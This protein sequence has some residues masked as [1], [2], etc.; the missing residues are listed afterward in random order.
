MST[1][2]ELCNHLKKVI[3]LLNEEKEALI[4]NDG[5]K[6]IEIVKLKNKYIEKLSQFSGLDIIENE[7][8]INLIQEINSLQ[9]VNLL[10]TRQALSYQDVLL[11]SISQSVQNASNTYSAKGNYEDSNNINLIDKKV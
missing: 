8:A 3:K 2:V 6:I 10:L 7:K 5:G 4:Q 9:E 11:D 1:V